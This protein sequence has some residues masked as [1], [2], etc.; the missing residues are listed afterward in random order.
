MMAGSSAEVTSN[1]PGSLSLLLAQTRYQLKLFY[2]V[3]AAMFFTL[4]LPLVMLIL[5]NA[6][7]GSDVVGSGSE[8]QMWPQRQFYTAGLAVFAAVTA[9]YTNLANMIPI[10]RDEGVLKRWRST[11]LPTWIYVGGAIFSSV[12]LAAFNVIVMLTLGVVA[13]GVE[14]DIAK[15]PAAIVTLMVGIASFA[16]LGMAVA[17]VVPTASAASAVAN[18]TILPLAF[19]SNVFLSVDGAPRWV[20]LLGDAF[21]LKAFAGSFQDAFNPAVTGAAWSPGRLG[22]IAVWGL[23]A[24]VVAVTRFR[25]EPSGSGGRRSRRSRAHATD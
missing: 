5:L 22:F 19:V 9:T 11:P 3:P 4:A 2:R 18:A 12:I 21:P 24:A 17:A 7:F 10:R 25:W 6:V 16:A 15:L 23:A 8:S 14:I 1:W 20:Q 13:Y